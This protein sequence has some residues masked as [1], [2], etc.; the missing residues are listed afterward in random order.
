MRLDS[1][2]TIIHR[3]SGKGD[4]LVPSGRLVFQNGEFYGTTFGGGS[5]EQGTI[6]SADSS[7]VK[8][9]H[10]FAGTRDGSIP[11]GLTPRGSQGQL[12]GTTQAGGRVS[13]GGAGSIFRYTP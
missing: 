9:L 3:F 8:I 10:S 12:Y 2:E 5:E 11:W 1:R 7:D 13:Y 4:G 6:Y